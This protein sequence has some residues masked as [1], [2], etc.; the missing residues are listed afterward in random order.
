VRRFVHRATLVVVLAAT[1]ALMA[2]PLGAPALAAFA[3]GG[4]GPNMQGGCGGTPIP[5]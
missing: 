2:A 1:M 3:D 5:C 4:S